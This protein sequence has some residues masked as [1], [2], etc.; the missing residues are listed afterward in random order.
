MKRL[1][2]YGIACCLLLTLG[3]CKKDNELAPGF[4]MIYQAEIVIQPGLST[5]VVHH[6]YIKDLS[7]RYLTY[8]SQYDKQDVDVTK[9]LP[10][11]FALNGTFGD[12]NYSFI[13]QAVLR[14]YNESAPNDFVEV[15]YRS[16]VPLDPGNS[17]PLI[18]N[19]PDIK[20]YLKGSR[21]SID[22]ALRLRNITQ[23]ETTTRLDLQFRAYY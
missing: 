9:I 17:L 21:F 15:A 7:T 20:K 1:C 11:Q 16:P 18:P 3:N 22:L 23:E 12:A 13:D 14:I 2:I 10:S 4:D 5:D 8:L 6:Y 19:Q